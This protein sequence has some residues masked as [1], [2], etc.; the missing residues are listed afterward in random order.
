MTEV[1]EAGRERL[2]VTVPVL[3]VDN[4]LPLLKDTELRV[5]LVVL[6]Q[7]RV[8]T[9][10]RDSAWLSHRELCR[11][12]GRASEAVSAAVET[13]SRKGLLA[14]SGE[15]G[16]N[17]MTARDRQMARG[18]QFYRTLFGGAGS[19]STRSLAP[20]QVTPGMLPDA[21]KTVSTDKP[22]TKEVTDY[23]SFRL[24]KPEAGGGEAGTDAQ[25]RIEGEKARIRE[26]LLGI[27]GRR[28]N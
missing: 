8:A 25:E 13:L 12:T 10:N 14:V 5:L 23:E 4:V 20:G 6:R 18:R 19:S 21:G 3:F 15:D 17:L 27:A 11:R 28:T 16:R 24:R 9:R 7:T 26:R 1:A 22:K 2:I